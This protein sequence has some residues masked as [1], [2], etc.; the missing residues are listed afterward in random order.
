MEND[1]PCWW[2]RLGRTLRRAAPYGAL[3]VALLAS[4]PSRAE[5]LS[6]P[7]STDGVSSASSSGGV[8]ATGQ[9]ALVF[10]DTVAGG[11]IPAARGGATMDGARVADGA[12]GRSGSGDAGIE[13]LSEV[14]TSP[15]K[16]SDIMRSIME[17]G[18]TRQ[19]G[20]LTHGF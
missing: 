17:A 1:P 3:A 16:D 18:G 10:P 19:A 12:S 15:V 7:G 11:G 13:G 5:M 14:D 20:P 9:S 4:S 8:G 2:T 6:A